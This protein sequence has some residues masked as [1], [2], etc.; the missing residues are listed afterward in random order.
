MRVKALEN[1]RRCSVTVVILFVFDWCLVS[2]LLVVWIVH[3]FISLSIFLNVYLF[4]YIRNVRGKVYSRNESCV[5][6]W[7][8]TFSLHTFYPIIA[9]TRR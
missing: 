5:L 4:V 2:M 8:S 3:F 6:N 9:L 7:I 1:Y